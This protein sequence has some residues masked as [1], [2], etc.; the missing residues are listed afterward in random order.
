ML[1]EANVPG[2]DDWY[3]ME[4]GRDLGSRFTHLKTLDS[5]RDGSYL[6]EANADPAVAE[7]YAK[8]VEKARL[9]FAETIVTQTTG[10]LQLRAFRTA[11]EGDSNGD[12]AAERIMRRNH[13]RTQVRN[14]FD[15][16]ATHGAA[17]GIVGIDD[18][19]QAFVTFRDSWSVAV[20]MNGLRPWVVDAALIVSRD[21]IEERDVFMLMRPGYMRVAVLA[22]KQSSVPTDGSPW[23]PT[24]DMEWETGPV[25][26]GFTEQVPVVPFTNPRGLGEFEAHLDSINRVTE[27]ILQRL[28]IT[29]MQAF[30][31]RA[32]IPEGG[33]MPEYYPEWHERAGQRIDY[34]ELFK[35]G[36]AA[37]WFLPPGAKLWESAQ[38]DIRGITEAEQRD[39]EHLAAVTGTPLYSLSPNANVA[40]EGAKLAR[41]TIR[42]KVR[43]RQ[44]RDSASFAQLMSLAFQAEGD[45]LRAEMSEIET[46]WGP[47]EFVARAD[48]AESARA[49]A[50]AGQSQRFIA[51][52]IYELS[53]DEMELEAQSRRE[54]QFLND[55]MGG[56]TNGLGS[57][58]SNTS[59]TP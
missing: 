28:T 13:F 40:A 9:T 39:L 55:V 22:A 32:I 30:R 53:P 38:T 41:E 25:P 2:S 54:E 12:P 24:A 49:A 16:K 8:F 6:V 17:Y 56:T 31:Q 37:L 15:A 27:D 7:A 35:G 21:D 59:D 57:T 18:D 36:P 1:T 5:Y 58:N 26:L 47:M 11:A 14:M 4:L 10:R 19:G 45:T 52:H 42:T 51:E 33:P 46:V 44:E 43:E 20:R 48:V 50:Q 34:N 23:V 3:L 29:A